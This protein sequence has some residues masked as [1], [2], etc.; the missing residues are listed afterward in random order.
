MND[1]VTRKHDLH[2]P[3]WQSSYVHLPALVKR[4]GLKRGAEVGVAFG[5]HC[6]AILDG[7]GVELL[8]GVDPYRHQRGYDDPMNL[9]QAAF[10]TLHQR[11]L[12]RLARFGGRYRHLRETSDGAIPQIDGLLD[13]VYI[14]ADHSYDGVKRDLGAW[15]GMVREGGLFSGHDYEHPQFPGVQKAVDEFF[16]RLGWQVTHAGDH[17]WWV[18]KG[19]TDISFVM[20]VFNAEKTLRA[21]LLS[22]VEGN[23]A[24]GDEIVV[25]D[26]GSTDGSAALLE[27]LQAELPALKMVRHERNRGGGAAR[28]TAVKTAKHPLLFC[29]DSDNILEP[30]TVTP[31]KAFLLGGGWDVAAFQELRYFRESPAEVTHRWVYENRAYGFSD[32]LDRHEVPGASGNYLFTRRSWEQAGGYPEDAGA[33]D[34][35]GFGL[36]Q[37]ATGA[38]LGILPGLGYRHRWGH[39][40]YWVR[41]SKETGF[42]ALAARLV[43][44]WAERLP[45]AARHRLY[46]KRETTWFETL[47]ARPLFPRTLVQSVRSRLPEC[48][49]GWR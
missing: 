11:S 14:D 25:C 5:G 15:F 45:A 41:Q 16:G 9:P 30:G 8:Y 10:D 36:R 33:L 40:S 42:S 46:E 26:D 6:E 38:R 13:F 18:V 7:T 28:N 17:V 39:E 27:S 44:P 34:A 43:E 4:L 3:S 12:D 37:A 29:L 32:Y 24:P 49:G 22:I 2:E 21:A 35:W 20:P 31:L 23:L 47:P 1:L 19:V 48:L